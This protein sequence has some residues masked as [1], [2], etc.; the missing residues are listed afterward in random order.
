MSKIDYK[1]QT[2]IVT[3]A[4]AGLGAEFARQLARRGANLVLVARRADRLESLAAELSRAHGVAVTCVARDLGLP[5]AGR[6]LWSELESRGIHATGLVNNAGF[7]THSAFTNEDP[8]RRSP[9]PSVIT[10]G[11][12]LA[13]VSKLLPRRLMVRF[14]GWMARR[15]PPQTPIAIVRP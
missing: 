2:I 13:L 6:T 3:G 9:P 15:Q 5:D 12:I 10:N 14:M 1:R 7:G 4:S 11:R 8:D